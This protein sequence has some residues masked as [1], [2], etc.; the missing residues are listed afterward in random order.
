[1]NA[2]E[3]AIA[4][5]ADV[6]RRIVQACERAGR[7]PSGVRLIAVGYRQAPEHRYDTRTQETRDV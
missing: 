5:L 6:R 1:M 3:R 2:E 4:G 7:D